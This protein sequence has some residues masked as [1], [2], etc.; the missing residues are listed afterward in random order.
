MVRCGRHTMSP[1][2]IESVRNSCDSIEVNF[3]RFG[4]GLTAS[5]FPSYDK[6]GKIRQA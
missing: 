2:F 5:S 4:W 3:G 1:R 6:G